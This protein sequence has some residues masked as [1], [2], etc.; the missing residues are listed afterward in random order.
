MRF[1]KFNAILLFTAHT[2]HCDFIDAQTLHA[3]AISQEIYLLELTDE[4]PA[5]FV[6][7]VSICS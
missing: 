5:V 3:S 1:P 2:N 6:Q 7:G 4:Y